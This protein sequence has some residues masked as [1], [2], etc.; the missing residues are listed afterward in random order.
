MIDKHSPIPIYHQLEE[1]IRQKIEN[2][3]YNPGDALPSEREYA[4]Q[5]NISRMTVRQAISNLVNERYLIR[6][7]GKGTFIAEQKLEQNLNGLTSFTEDMIARG[8]TPSNKLLNFEIIPAKPSIAQQ[9]NIKEH[10]P[11]YE[12]KR[13]RLAQ[14]IPMALERTYV[15]ANLIKGLTDD[16]VE[17]SLYKY[18]EENLGLKIG[19]ASQIFEATHA[20]E[21]EIKYLE[22]PEQSPVLFMRRVTKLDNG[23]V[24]ELVKSSYRADRYKF[25]L[26]LE[27]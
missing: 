8:M 24:F 4:E 5:L 19:R 16:I 15:S 9:L 17:S 1:Q 14:G 6:I 25:M 11:V 21:E 10:A 18:I 2:G 12:I 3:E 7:K 23:T 27:R 22:I 20:N 26:D 13:I